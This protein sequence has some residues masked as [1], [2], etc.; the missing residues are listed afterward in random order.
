MTLTTEFLI[1]GSIQ[2]VGFRPFIFRIA[3]S[4]RITGFVQNNGNF[5]K[6]IAQG[7]DGNLDNFFRDITDKKPPL[8]FIEHIDRKIIANNH[9]FSNFSIIKSDIDPS[10]KTASYIPP[11][12]AICDNCLSDMIIGDR[13]ERKNYSFTSCVDC[14]PRYSV[15]KAIPYDRPLTTMDE[16][17]LCDKCQKEYKN[18]LD[19]RFHAQTTCC[20]KCG[21]S[22][23]LLDSSGNIID[24]NEESIVRKS[25]ELLLKGKILAIK[26][27]SGT[28]LAC[29]PDEY[30][31]VNTLRKSKGDRL[32]KPFALMSYSLEEIKKYA[33]IENKYL[34]DL[35]FSPR[36]PIV[37]H[38]KNN[39]FPLASNPAPNLQ[40]IG[41]MLPYSGFHY[42]LLDNQKLQTLI[43]TSAN[44]SH[45]PIEIYNDE[46][47]K[48]LSDIVD[49][50]VLHNRS[51]HQRVDDSVIKPFSLNL[52]SENLAYFIRRSRGYTPEPITVPLY[53]SENLLVGLGSEL[54]T[55]PAL[56][57]QGKLFFTQYIGNL[58][59]EK[60]YQ[61]Y[62]KS[63]EHMKGLLQ[64]DSV[65]AVAHDIHPLYLSTEYAKELNEKYN[66]QIFSFQHHFAHAASLLVDNA[67]WD[68]QAIIGTADGLGLGNDNSIWG[69]EILLSDLHH[70]KR[71]DHLNY[72]NQPGGDAATKYPARMLL[73]YLYANQWEEQQIIKKFPNLDKMLTKNVLAQM[74]NQL[75][76]PKTSSTGRFLDTCSYLLGLCSEETYEGEPAIVL[77]GAGWQGINTQEPNPIIEFAKKNDL[78]LNFIPVIPLLLDLQQKHMSKERIAYYVQDFVGWSYA[79]KEFDYALSEG[80]KYVGFTG[81]VA[82]N[83]IIINS[84]IQT[85]QNQDKNMNILLH[86]QISPGDGGIAGGQVALLSQKLN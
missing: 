38:K 14:G 49:Y 68:E 52:K 58:R 55:T 65:Y 19:R 73:S 10:I 57:T 60:T 51:I 30:E 62:K 63:I 61:F 43:M 77:E 74:N 23:S 84:F 83:E 85:I 39:P 24:S 5:V 3:T 86:K 72:V 82:F 29:R 21:P 69:G 31:I 20:S 9:I 18:P 46:I 12:T 48:N 26:G 22:Y 41:D 6:I 76:S 40:N 50:F 32:R 59:Y 75:N 78:G 56:L 44:R 2:G 28:H 47:F 64:R 17:P 8:A 71:L 54:H 34:E 70:F 42:Q 16:F 15:I 66:I 1:T 81:G 33:L 13:P 11:D 7:L 27:I 36:R 37:L 4:N 79:R 67:V 45:L 25:Q 80:I 35:L 53:D